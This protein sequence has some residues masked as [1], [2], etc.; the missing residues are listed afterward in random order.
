MENSD[1]RVSNVSSLKRRTTTNDQPARLAILPWLPFMRFQE[2]SLH[3][4]ATTFL[5]T[6]KDSKVVSL[7]W[8]DG[9]RQIIMSSAEVTFKWWCSLF[10]NFS[11]KCTKNSGLGI[12]RLN[13]WLGQ[14]WS[15]W[16][17]SNSYPSTPG[18]TTF[19]HLCHLNRSSDQTQKDP[20]PPTSQT[21]SGECNM[22]SK[23][24]LEHMGLVHVSSCVKMF[25]R[26]NLPLG[27]RRNLSRLALIWV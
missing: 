9:S 11:P 26:Y 19:W 8:G 25:W 13:D 5:E 27:E 6:Q 20:Q 3:S 1:L 23:L 2:Q 14:G 21:K 15:G 16:S 10:G 17:P 18:R 22:S 12:V 24:A 4:L 7:H